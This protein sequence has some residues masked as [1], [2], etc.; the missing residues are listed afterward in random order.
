MKR[1][2]N[3]SHYLQIIVDYESAGVVRIDDW[4][5]ISAT[6]YDAKFQGVHTKALE[7]FLVNRCKEIGDKEDYELGHRVFI[8]ENN[9]RFVLTDCPKEE[10]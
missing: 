1:V 7:E 5:S 8:D 6:S 10:K 4:Y 9:V 2:T 3:T